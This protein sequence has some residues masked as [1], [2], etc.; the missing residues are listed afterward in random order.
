M[1]GGLIEYWHYTG[2]GTYNDAAARAILSQ[3]GP[4]N[5]F[6][7][8]Q[9]DGNDD[10]GWWALAAMSAAEYGLPSPPGAPS[11]ISIA[12]NVFTEFT[13]RWD[14]ARCNGGMKWKIQ[15]NADGYHYKSSIANGVF[16]QLAARLARFTGNA[17]YL[18][19][20][21]RSFDWMQAVGLI[22]KM[23]NVYDGTDDAKG[24]GCIDVDH[25][26]WSYNV[27]IFLYGSAVLSDYTGDGKW[28]NRTAGL[29]GASATFFD[30]KVMYETRCEKSGTC[31]VDQRSFKAYLARWLGATAVIAPW[32]QGAITP[33]LAASANGAAASCSGGGNG[34][35]C[36]SRWFTNNFDGVS[37]VGEQLAALEVVYGLLA[38]GT[39][40]PQGHRR[41]KRSFVA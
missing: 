18:N 36:G 17:D 34:Q 8:P 4:Q 25:D 32:T 26:Q 5:N 40:K 33:L 35:M 39:P 11:W 10:Q 28:S 1:W 15:P 41:A 30:S 22:D 2:D 14:N 31:N 6:Q 20:A 3:A 16:F 7:M 21:S 38:P 19:W 27:G 37:G 13:T 23:W 9:C 24:A 12:Q 29:L